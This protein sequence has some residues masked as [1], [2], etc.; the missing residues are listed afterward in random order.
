[1]TVAA[2]ATAAIAVS[3]TA[4]AE[5]AATAEATTAVEAAATTVTASPVTPAPVTTAM[6]RQGRRGRAEQ[7]SRANSG[8]QTYLGH[9][10]HREPPSLYQ[11]RRRQ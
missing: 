3:E 9:P 4:T 1:M 5:T 8:R 11:G 7:A 6:L 2:I 10:F